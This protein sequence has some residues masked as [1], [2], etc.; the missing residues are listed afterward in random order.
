VKAEN[1]ERQ[2]KFTG[3]AMNSNNLN[4]ERVSTQ[5]VA[6]ARLSFPRQPLVRVNRL[7]CVACARLALMVTPEEAAEIVYKSYRNVAA[8]LNLLE[9]AHSLKT[10]EGATL[11]CYDSLFPNLFES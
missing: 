9:N 8:N 7:W 2:M 3:E 5:A 10:S 4:I 1:A 11:I 6:T